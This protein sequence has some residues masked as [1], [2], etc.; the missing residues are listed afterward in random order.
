MTNALLGHGAQ[1][2]QSRTMHAAAEK[3][4]VNL[5][6]ALVADGGDMD[7]KFDV[8]VGEGEG[9]AFDLAVK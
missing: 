7:G 1:M 2:A 4:R 5:L 3:G 6:K 8:R 9:D